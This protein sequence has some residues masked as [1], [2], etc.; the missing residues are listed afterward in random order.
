MPAPA[1]PPCPGTVLVVDDDDLFLRV[2]TAV[3]KHAGFTV[4]GLG[5]PTR[6]VDR[7]KTGRFDAVVSDLRMPQVDGVQLLKAIRSFDTAIPVLLMSGQPTIEAAMQAIEHRAVRMLQK[8]FDVDVMIDAVRAAVRSRS[9]SAPSQLHQKLDRSLATLHMAYQPIVRGSV[10]RSVAWEALVRCRDGAKHALDLLETAELTGRVHEL[11]RM[12]RDTVAR[13]AAGLP[14]GA[15]L[16]VNLHPRDLDDPHL[17]APDAP[18]SGL[19]RRVVL[20]ITERASLEHVDALASKL[21]ALRSLGFRLAVDDLGA[22]YAG[23]S[24]FASVEPDFVKLDG[25]LVRGLPSSSSQRLV[26][27]SMLE[28]ARQLGSEVI[29]EG[30]ETEAER[31]ALTALG[32]DW[33][34]GYLFAKPGAPFI[35]ANVAMLQAA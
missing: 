19:A 13:D 29:A 18:L 15:L 30:I 33:M 5:D 34:Q 25:S 32:I 4:E 11:G 10:R 23:L 21:F 16:F 9:S 24:T 1:S 20:E 7:L 2:C 14:E 8:P 27:A 12:V 17:I 28:L 35:E 6:V 22:G 3:L 31:A 26:V